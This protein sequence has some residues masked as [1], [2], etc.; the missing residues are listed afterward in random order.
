VKTCLHLV[1]N[2]S[3]E[4]NQQIKM[5]WNLTQAK[6]QERLFEQFGTTGQNQIS[7]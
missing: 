4:I 7:Q 5:A 6:I 2:Q 3:R 1:A